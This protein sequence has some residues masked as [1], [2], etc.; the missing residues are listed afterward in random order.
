[1]VFWRIVASIVRPGGRGTR[2]LCALVVAAGALLSA[3]MSGFGGQAALPPAATIRLSPAD[4]LR[5]SREGRQSVQAQTA[6]GLELTLW[7]S[8][9]LVADPIAMDIDSRGAM[10]VSAS[11]RSGQFLDLRQHA[12]WVPDVH[13]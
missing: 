7:A 10:Y 13:T 12:N 11:P 8:G 3:T 9:A 6:D 1:M 4:A 2:R 5:L